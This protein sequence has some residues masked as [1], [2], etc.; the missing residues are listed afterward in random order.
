VRR[1]HLP[2]PP[3]TNPLATRLSS[4]TSPLLAHAPNTLL[5]LDPCTLSM[6]AGTTLHLSY[7]D[8]FLSTLQHPIYHVILSPDIPRPRGQGVQRK[9]LY[10]SISTLPSPFPSPTTFKTPTHTLPG[11]LN[12]QQ[13]HQDIE[14]SL[15]YT[16]A[17]Y[18]IT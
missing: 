7:S 12:I 6:G 8:I 4:R 16:D 17:S 13:Y 9:V 2:H 3:R 11:R 1:W 14:H 10:S 18:S 15:I 5:H